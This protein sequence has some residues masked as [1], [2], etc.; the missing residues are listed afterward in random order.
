M[1]SVLRRR[2]AA[3]ADPAVTPPP[4]AARPPQPF[5]LPAPSFKRRRIPEMAAGALMVA[6][7]ALVFLWLAGGEQSRSVVLLA[8]DVPRGQVLTGADLVQA[9]IATTIDV[10]AVAWSDASSIVGRL[11][12]A[13]MPARSLV[14]PNSVAVAPSLPAGH[15]ELGVVLTAG[16][17]PTLEL[18]PA[19]VVDV[20]RASANGS[21]ESTV[22]ASNVTV[23]SVVRGDGSYFVSLVVVEDRV[24]PVSEAAQANELRLVRV[25][26]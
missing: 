23:R 11:A 15:R 4:P 9:E 19:D 2:R 21:G 1:A 18:A 8:N 22:V 25:P 17:M 3:E 26:S 7:G 13:D 6:L 16:P 10:A 14:T 5:T 20:L 12:V 24:V